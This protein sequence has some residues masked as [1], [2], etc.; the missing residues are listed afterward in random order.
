MRRLVP[1]GLREVRLDSD[2]KLA[3]METTLARLLSWIGAADSK[4]GMVLAI[5]TA[6]LGTLAALAP[7]YSDW[8]A[9]PAAASATAGALLGMSI[10]MLSLASF[11]R[12]EGPRG[13]LIFFGEI[14]KAECD[15]FVRAI[16]ARSADEYLADLATQCHRNA[17]IACQKY[18]W[19]R[20]ALLALYL[21]L[22]P[23]LIAISL[24]YKRK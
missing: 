10:L 18:A 19:V 24:L 5:D 15:V 17:Q 12:M 6:M 14:G 11:P 7:R 3:V 4:T 21:S 8:T 2:K 20:R 22:P 16:H 9:C 23:W 13:S 1:S